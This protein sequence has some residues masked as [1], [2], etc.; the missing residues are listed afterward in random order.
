MRLRVKSETMSV[1][2]GGL[3]SNVAI[4][5]Q[6][7]DLPAGLEVT[8]T[9]IRADRPAAALVKHCDGRFSWLPVACL[10]PVKGGA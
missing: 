7:F 3:A 2:V 9:G 6:T 5:G 8:D 4:V 1:I 10:E